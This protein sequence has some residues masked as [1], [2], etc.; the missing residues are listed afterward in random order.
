M[1]IHA[2]IK[3]L[4][5]AAKLS[6][7]GLA[8]RVSAID[9][10]DEPITRQSVQYWEKAVGG[11]APKRTRMPAVAKALGTTV[12]HLLRAG[13]SPSSNLADALAQIGRALQQVRPERREELVQQ[14]SLWAV[15]PDEPDY[16]ARMLKLLTPAEAQAEPSTLPE[17]RQSNG[18]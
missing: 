8:E 17:K 18:R 2:E 12:E 3:R 4:R 13:H 6:Q 9:P 10:S 14:F 5:L 7:K 15:V 1:S 16:A 11:T